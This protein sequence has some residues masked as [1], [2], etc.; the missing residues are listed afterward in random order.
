MSLLD[1]AVALLHRLLVLLAALLPGP[2]PVQLGLAIVVLTAA[3]RLALVPLSLRSLRGTRSREALQPQ[4]QALR[5]KH[6]K[7]PASLA[8]EIQELHRRAGVSP[9][10]GMGPMLLTLPVAMALYRMLGLLG[11]PL[12]THWIPL[13]VTGAPAA[14]VLAALLGGLLLVAW[15]SSRQQP[16]Q[17]AFLRVLPF[18]TVACAMVVPLAV[19]V[20]LLTTTAWTVAERAVLPRLL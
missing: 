18:G 4:L 15:L 5:K 13:A 20:Y 1:P 6:H 14:V 9:L 10:A 19:S 3:V 12:G 2:E 17:P 7:D 11:N 16:A 8:R